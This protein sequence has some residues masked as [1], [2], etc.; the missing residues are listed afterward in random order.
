[1]CLLWNHIMIKK[2]PIGT[3]IRYIGEGN[4]RG[5]WE[6]GWTGTIVGI[7]GGSP[8]IFLPQSTFESEYS[9][10]I[11]K[12]TVQTSWSNIEL[13]RPQQLMFDFMY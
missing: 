8:L 2:Y 1:M 6:R 13:A 10:A 3:K 7:V 4:I 11:C 9:T 5:W 12:A